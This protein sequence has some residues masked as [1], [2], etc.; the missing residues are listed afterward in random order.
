MKR[1]ESYDRQG[2]WDRLRS[3]GVH[4]IVLP[5]ALQN[6]TTH[7]DGRSKKYFGVVFWT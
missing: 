5:G 7:A 1:L 4:R 3:T 2:D 6:L